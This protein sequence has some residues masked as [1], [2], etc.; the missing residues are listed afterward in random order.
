M[1]FDVGN[2]FVRLKVNATDN[3]GIARVRFKR[4]DISHLQW[5]YLGTVTAP[6]YEINFNT[7]TLFY[8][9]NEIRAETYDLAGNSNEPRIW[10]YRLYNGFLPVIRR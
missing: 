10:L 9:W 7:S 8:E 3:S 4:W 5:V 1:R 2:Q 6:P